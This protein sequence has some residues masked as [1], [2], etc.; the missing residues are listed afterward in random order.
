MRFLI[1]VILITILSALAEYFLPWWSMAIVS[2]L[3]SL[4]AGFRP[5]RSFLLGFVGVGLC[6]LVTALMHDMA[7][8]HILSTRMA[9]LFHLPNYLLFIVVTVF[10]GGLI[11]GLSACAGALFSPGR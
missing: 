5:G 1:A 11:G 8:Q 4:F 2:F 6:W 10:L 7:N 9:A 3:V